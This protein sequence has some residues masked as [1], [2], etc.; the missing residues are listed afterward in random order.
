MVDFIFLELFSWL[1]SLAD[2]SSSVDLVFFLDASGEIQQYQFDLT[3]Q[4]VYNVLQQLD[5]NAEDKHRVGVT[6]FASNVQ[7]RTTRHVLESPP[8]FVSFIVPRVS[9][10]PFGFATG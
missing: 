3:K 8:R 2:C 7:V 5:L 9:A 1:V 4:F 10:L 6:T